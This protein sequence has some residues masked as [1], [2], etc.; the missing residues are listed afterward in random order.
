MAMSQLDSFIWKF[1]QL[2]HSGMNAKLEIKSEAGKAIVNLT[3]EVE[4]MPRQ[5]RNGPARQRRRKRRAAARAAAAAEQV[6]ADQHSEHSEEEEEGRNSTDDVEE[7]DLGAGQASEPKDEII[8]ENISDEKSEQI[9]SSV[10][11]IPVRRVNA[12]DATIEKVVRQKLLVKGVKVL[13]LF[14]QRSAN[15][16][17]S[18]CD[19]CVEP[20][21]GKKIDETD[22]EFENC[23]V[24]PLFGGRP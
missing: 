22:F 13:E 9:A 24:I 14:I 3:A 16:I 8:D 17:F 5:S 4:T 11:I 23:R 10:S 21:K 20:V 12:E 18:R 7:P 2:L 6:V 1:K 19:A 15:G